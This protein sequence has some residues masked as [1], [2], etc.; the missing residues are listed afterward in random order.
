[1]FLLKQV[2]AKLGEDAV[3][4]GRTLVALDGATATF[5]DRDTGL[6][7]QVSAGLLIGADGIHSTVRRHFYPHEGKPAWNGVS[8]FRA[9]TKLAAGAFDARQLWAGHVDQKFIAYPIRLDEDGIELN[10]VADLRTGAPG[11]EPFEDWNRRADRDMLIDR[12]AGWRWA[13]VDVPAIIAG[14][15]EVFEFPMVDRDPLPRWSFDRVT[16]I[17]DAAHPMYPIGSNGATQAI[18]DG[19]VL[20]HHLATSPDPETGLSRYEEARREPTSRIVLGNR[21]QGPDQVLELAR[22][23]LIDPQAD[24]EAV[25]PYAERAEIAAGYK[26]LAGFD[27]RVLNE[28][29]SYTV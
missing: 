21:A 13:G 23:R 28:R 10:W 2:R 6:R 24:I 18:I 15:G 25:L 26:Q 19:R 27:P 17:G 3:R 22:Q 8:L 7:E 20:A 29:A 9:V 1:M 5:E 12:F 16:L 4:T 14:A 11:A